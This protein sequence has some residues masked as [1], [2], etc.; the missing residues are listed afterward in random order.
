MRLALIFFCWSDCFSGSETCEDE[1]PILMPNPVNVSNMT[2]NDLVRLSIANGE[3]IHDI[4][5]SE[6]TVGQSVEYMR[7]LLLAHSHVLASLFA[8]RK[9]DCVTESFRFAVMVF[10]RNLMAI[11][12]P[13]NRFENIRESCTWSLNTLCEAL[14]QLPP[15]PTTSY[16]THE[17]DGRLTT[18]EALRI[19]TFKEDAISGSLCLLQ[20]AI[21]SLFT[22]GDVILDIG[23]G[24]SAAHSEWLNKTG[25]VTSIA[26]DGSPSVGFVS[27]GIVNEVDARNSSWISH[28]MN[29]TIPSGVD[30]AWCINVV[31]SVTEEAASNILENIVNTVNP[32]KGI[33]LVSDSL[34]ENHQ[35]KIRRSKYRFLN[36]L[37]L[38]NGI[39]MY[40]FTSG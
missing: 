36:N 38:C 4:L 31:N 35:D 33:V 28:F 14:A 3:R 37:Q 32:R 8:Q 12:E 11:F 7:G 17:N 10:L 15:D 24:P 27:G 20:Y 25:L 39:N 23:S 19:H 18:L 1:S 34:T 29:G 16:Y 2:C 9:E 26:I 30:W 22:L 13:K 5:M 40:L 6:S 21:S